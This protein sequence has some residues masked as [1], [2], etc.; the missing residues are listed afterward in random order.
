MVKKYMIE[1]R[2]CKQ[3]QNQHFLLVVFTQTINIPGTYCVCRT[4]R[5][6]GSEQEC[7]E[8]KSEETVIYYGSL[9]I[10]S[11]RERGEPENNQRTHTYIH[12][13]RVCDTQKRHNRRTT[14]IQHRRK[15][16]TPYHSTSPVTCCKRHA[17]NPTAFFIIIGYT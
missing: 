4:G 6:E 2:A 3:K 5:Y 8:P 13:K 11:N 15:P 7:M 14:T 1:I 17:S 9:S 10:A 16:V 12:Q